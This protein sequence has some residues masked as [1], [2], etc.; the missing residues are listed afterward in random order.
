MHLYTTMYNINEIC[1][2]SDNY[3]NKYND[4]IEKNTLDQYCGE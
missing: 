3:K 2:Y 4:E 1:I